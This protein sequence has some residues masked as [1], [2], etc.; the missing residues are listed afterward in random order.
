MY[1][2]YSLFL[3]GYF[4]FCLFPITILFVCHYY[5]GAMN[6]Y[7]HTYLVHIYLNACNFFFMGEIP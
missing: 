3:M 2:Y 7:L 6:M 5:E 1:I 4:L